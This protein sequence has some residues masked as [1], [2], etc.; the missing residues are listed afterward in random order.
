MS[1]QSEFDGIILNHQWEFPIN[2][3][4]SLTCPMENITLISDL[5]DET[6]QSSLLAAKKLHAE[7]KNKKEAIMNS[8]T[9][10]DSF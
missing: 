10:V 4:I 8:K 9:G 2:E 1:S 6:T 3:K 7:Y 5:I